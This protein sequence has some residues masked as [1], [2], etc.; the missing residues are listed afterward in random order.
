M[1]R[2][3]TKCSGKGWLRDVIVAVILSRR[4][5]R[6]SNSQIRELSRSEPARGRAKDV[7]IRCASTAVQFPL[8]LC[9]RSTCRPC[10]HEGWHQQSKLTVLIINII[11]L[12]IFV[13]MNTQGAVCL[14]GTPPGYYLRA[15]E[16]LM[17]AQVAY[18]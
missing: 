3:D 5:L 7:G 10:P 12:I 16:L 14:D 1:C 6:A 11:L 17:R 15:G 8:H 9:E 13:N 4:D 18:N 2:I